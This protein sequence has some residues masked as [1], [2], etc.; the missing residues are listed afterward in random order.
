[1]VNSNLVAFKS[2]ENRTSKNSNLKFLTGYQLKEQECEPKEWL[3]SNLWRERE[4]M[5][6]YAPPG[7]GK[8]WL[9]WSFAAAVAG[10][11]SISPAGWESPKARKT[12]ILD[13]E[14]DL[15][16]LQERQIQTGIAV[17]SDYESFMENLVIFSRQ[18]QPM[19]SHILDL[20]KKDLQ[21]RIIDVILKTGTE[22]LIIDNFSTLVQVSDENSASSMQGFN[23]FLIGL[24]QLG[25][26]T[27]LVHHSRKKTGNQKF[28][29]RGSSLLSIPFE[30]ILQLREVEDKPEKGCAFEIVSD[31]SRNL[32]EIRIGL[33]LDPDSRQWNEHKCI[34]ENIRI[35]LEV[36]KE[37]IC[38]NQSELAEKCSLDQSSI[39]RLKSQAI[40]LGVLDEDEYSESLKKAKE[41]RDSGSMS[42]NMYP[43]QSLAKS[44]MHI[45]EEEWDKWP[46]QADKYFV[47]DEE[48]EEY[49]DDNDGDF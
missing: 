32:S 34:P 33:W 24:K 20:S 49:F 21:D 26:S 12:M 35:L 36:L 43:V 3:L 18:D 17:N 45:K 8:S 25:I 16:D 5:M 31:K 38:I 28:A 1:M 27:L 14:M 23:Q 39:S 11:G 37:S 41:S 4:M 40:K 2:N 42:E 19:V 30:I 7:L 6:I 47:H 48:D 29:Y 10:K 13:G 22:V 15:Q 44:Y 46:T 9:A